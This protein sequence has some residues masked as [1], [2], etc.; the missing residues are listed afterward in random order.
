MCSGAP[1]ARNVAANAAIDAGSSR[2]SGAVVTPARPASAARAVRVTRRHKYARTGV[3]QRAHGGEAEARIAAGDNGSLACRCL[4]GHAPLSNLMAQEST[5][6]DPLTNLLPMLHAR[7]NLST[8][9]RAGGDW[10]VRV[11]PYAGQKFNAMVQGGAWLQVDGEEPVQLREGDCF[12]LAG[13]HGF[14]IASD[15][16]LTPQ[17]AA[18]VF[19]SAADGVAHIGAGNEVEIVAGR[20]TLAPAL[21]PFLAASLPAV[22]VV[23]MLFIELMR[24]AMEGQDAIGWLGALAAP[25]L[26]RALRALHADPARTWTAADLAE[27]AHMSRSGFAAAFKW[28]VGVAPLAYLTRWR[29]QQAGQALRQDGV[30]VARAAESAGFASES[31][32]GHAFRRVYGCSPGRYA[33]HGG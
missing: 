31:A 14:T 26:G 4:P 16:A 28:S 7:S 21:A 9:M 2:S 33:A 29:L 6:N 24:A 15:L 22:T 23:E 1:C 8:G 19:A 20:M 17:P 30:T 12:L 27:R 18:H 13:G 11:A 5:M 25:R 10:S 3:D 32:F